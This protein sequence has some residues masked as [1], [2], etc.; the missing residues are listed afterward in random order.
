MLTD[1][2]TFSRWLVAR[3][4][5]WFRMSY[6]YDATKEDGERFNRD[7][8]K[9]SDRYQYGFSFQVFGMFIVFL[10]LVSC[11][12]LAFENP[13]RTQRLENATLLSVE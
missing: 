6:S 5:S 7:S 9:V 2:R 4:P 3:G 12:L 13:L 11:L 10:I 1:V 8:I